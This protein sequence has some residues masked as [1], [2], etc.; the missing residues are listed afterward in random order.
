MLTL[1]CQSLRDH[2]ILIPK[3]KK[4]TDFLLLSETRLSDEE[5]VQ[6][7]DFDRIHFTVNFKRENVR[8]APVAICIKTKIEPDEHY[9]KF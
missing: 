8:A 7:L 6:L 4:K 2:E 9:A 5:D 3:K 1:N